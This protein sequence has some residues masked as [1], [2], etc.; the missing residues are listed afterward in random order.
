MLTYMIIRNFAIIDA[1]EV[2][3]S[4]GFTVI[5]GETGAGKSILINALNLLLGGRASSDIV[6]ADTDR[7]LVEGTFSLSEERRAR[8]DPLLAEAGIEV[9]D[10]LMIRRVISRKTGR[11]RAFLNGSVVPVG[12]LKGIARGL[13]DISGQHE[14]YSLLNPDGHVTVLDHFGGL[15][16]RAEKISIDIAQMHEL[17]REAKRLRHSERERLARV[18]FL[19]FQTKEIQDTLLDPEEEKTLEQQVRFLQNAEMLRDT[20]YQISQQLY[21][22]EN[23]LTGALSEMSMTLGRLSA[24]D[25]RLGEI[26][27]GFETASIQ[28]DEAAQDIRNYYKG[29]DTDPEELEE[30]EERLYQHS[31]LARKYGDDY[32]ETIAQLEAMRAELTQLEGAENRIEEAEKEYDDIQER[33]MSQAR[34][35]S[36]LRKKTAQRLKE[37]IESELSF[38]GMARCQ[39]EVSMHHVGPE[40]EHLDDVNLTTTGSLNDRGLDVIEFLICPNPG[41]GLKPLAR[42][43]SGG[44]LSRI[45]LAIKN[46]LM[47]TD[48]VSTYVF[49]EVDTGIGG[50]V[51]VA[52][53]EKIRAVARNKQVISITHLPQIAAFADHH[54]KVAK[55]QTEGRTTSTLKQLT[56]EQR[57]VEVARMLGG[58]PATKA[59]L[60]HAAEMIARSC[61]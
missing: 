9:C 23:A 17:R 13:V 31:Q 21:E 47:A 28:F 1:L 41:E 53:G 58:T 29:V 54:V 37:L 25:E 57:V 7:A 39:F 50:G 60:E 30:T 45:M 46:G 43:A 12:I 48:P 52:V 44:E 11:S 61:T 16:E 55:I 20:T 4:G 34:A 42:I 32:D 18:D 56:R 2:E 40:G 35:L 26:A 15:R 33:V 10:E 8:I 14:H 3:L 59:T 49:D 36:E 22:G 6:R 24:I 5:T 51:A 19:R 38:L 27:E